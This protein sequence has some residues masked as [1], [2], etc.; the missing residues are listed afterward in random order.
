MTWC[1]SKGN[2][3]YFET[4]A[5]EAINVE[6]AFQTVSKNALQQE[7]EEQMYVAVCQGDGLTE[8]WTG[9]WIIQTQSKSIG[10]VHRTT[11]AIVDLHNGYLL[12]LCHVSDECRRLLPICDPVECLI[13]CL[14][15]EV[16]YVTGPAKD[17]E[18]H[19]EVQ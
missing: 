18:M 14:T 2:I 15:A 5:K 8:R 19:L 3:P 7:A 6:Q 1:Q 11:G 16:S 4:S 12:F 10:R 9:M 17:E 13:Y